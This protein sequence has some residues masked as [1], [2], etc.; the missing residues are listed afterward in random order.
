M[1]QVARRFA[2]ALLATLLICANAEK[3]PWLVDYG[4]SYQSWAQRVSEPLAADREPLWSAPLDTHSTIVADGVVFFV[5]DGMLMAVDVSSGVVSWSHA[6]GFTGPLAHLDG[7]VYAGQGN[8]LVALDA[9]TGQRAWFRKL[10]HGD[11]RSIVPH[12]D[13]LL[14][15]GQMWHGGNVL[16]RT[17]GQVIYTFG[18]FDQAWPALLDSRLL[19]LREYSGEP[20]FYHA[21]LHDLASGTERWRFGFSDGLIWRAD[22][23]VYFVRQQ[24]V[25][26][27]V[28][29]PR[30]IRVVDEA[31]GIEVAE[32]EYSTD[33][34]DGS[35][36]RLA[37]HYF[38]TEEGMAILS[39]SLWTV[40]GFPLG[41]AN[42]ADWS[43]SL[44]APYIAGPIG[45]VYISG[46]STGRLYATQVPDGSQIELLGEGAAVRRL[47]VHGGSVYVGRDDGYLAVIDVESGESHFGAYVGEAEFGPIL[48]SGDYLI[49]QLGARLLVFGTAERSDEVSDTSREALEEIGETARAEAERLLAR[50]VTLRID[51]LRVHGDWAFL[52]SEMLG[53]DGE[54]LD[55]TGT[56]LEE[57]ASVGGASH[58][59]CA[60]LRREAG[61]WTLVASCLGA[62]DVAWDGWDREYGAPD[63][64]FGPADL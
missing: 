17:S 40:H 28:R 42:E 36:A 14:A 20:H 21:V 38:M 8:A 43:V 58:V 53:P 32:W 50:P 62:T 27:G 57:A 37:P 5:S 9:S 51:H 48:V 25:V 23:L 26:S 13:L 55:Y 31:S 1:R 46:G 3:E 18:I 61:E 30:F 22:G 2:A 44:S 49:V 10:E 33:E 11:I 52:L 16:K 19:H 63:E 64:V 7:T 39:G 15:M 47:D 6:G 56:Y 4:S 12:A 59:F 29:T 34:E 60:L 35:L 45:N 54:L 24:F 41:G